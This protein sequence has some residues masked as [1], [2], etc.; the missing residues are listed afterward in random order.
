[1][2]E[3][4][5]LLEVIEEIRSVGGSGVVVF[6]AMYIFEEEPAQYLQLLSSLGLDKI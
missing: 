1:M 3:K 4:T 5:K 2:V 6:P